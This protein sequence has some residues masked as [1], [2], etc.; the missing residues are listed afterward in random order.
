MA[1]A[2]DIF[3]QFHLH[4]AVLFRGVHGAG[5]GFTRLDKAQWLR[6]AP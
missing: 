4:D 2:C 3:I 6:T 1:E 5:F